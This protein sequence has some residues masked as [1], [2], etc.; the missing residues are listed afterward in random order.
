MVRDPPEQVLA[1]VAA[2]RDVLMARGFG[3]SWNESRY[4]LCRS[5][6][7]RRADVAARLPDFVREGTSVDEAWEFISRGRKKPRDQQRFI[8]E[9]FRPVFAYLEGRDGGPADDRL[10][11][12]L[13]PDQEGV[14]VAWEKALKRR[15]DDPDG[16]LT[17]ARTLLETLLKHMLEDFGER[18]E[19]SDDL[20]KLYKAVAKKLNLAPEDHT[21]EVFKRILGGCTSVVEGLG[22]VRSK[23][24]DAHGHGR[25]TWKVEPRHAELAVNLAGAMATFLVL[26]K[27]ARVGVPE[28]VAR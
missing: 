10:G 17:A 3:N 13:R 15:D 25:R 23:I 1:L 16:A 22:S 20:P 9:G 26:T 12:V 5:R 27:Q 14:R 21:E 4:R 2:M 28:G 7:I 6:L 19:S 24:G 18:Y 11:D 8:N